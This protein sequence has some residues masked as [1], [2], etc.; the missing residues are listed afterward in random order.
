MTV[1]VKTSGG[2]GFFGLLTLL[3]IGLKLTHIIELSWLWVFSPLWGL[4]LLYCGIFAIFGCVI[5]VAI[6]LGRIED[7]NDARKRKT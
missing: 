7:W 1:T 4:V 6:I 3:L 5:L 2:L